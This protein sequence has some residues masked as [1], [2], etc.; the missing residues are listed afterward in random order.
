M[1]TNYYVRVGECENPCIHCKGPEAIHLG[2]SSAG[3]TFSFRA[4]PEL[5]GTGCSE[6]G[7]DRI[8]TDFP[9]WLKLLDLGEIEDEYGQ[10]VTRDA[11]LAKIESKRG[12]RDNMYG[13]DFRDAGGN[14]FT[15]AEFS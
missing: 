3:W 7:R 15:S 6:L 2:K 5:D 8:V 12:G 1:G 14:R 11:L 9:S 10:P 4:Y 13:S